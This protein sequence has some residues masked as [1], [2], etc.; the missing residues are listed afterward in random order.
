MCSVWY[1]EVLSTYGKVNTV[2]SILKCMHV[3]YVYKCLCV[4]QGTEGFKVL[5]LSSV[6]DPIALSATLAYMD[7]GVC[8]TLIIVDLVKAVSGK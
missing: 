7:A 5:C 6:T 4:L 2:S 8:V 1:A 3:L